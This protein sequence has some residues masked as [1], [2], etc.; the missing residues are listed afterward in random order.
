MASGGVMAVK[1]AKDQG[2][3]IRPIYPASGECA[4]I[5]GLLL[6]GKGWLI[7]AVGP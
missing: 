7:F 6:P 3:L 2:G 5:P 4:T 1:L